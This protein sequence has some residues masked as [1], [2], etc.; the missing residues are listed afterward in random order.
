MPSNAI[1][2]SST[3]VHRSGG[4]PCGVDDMRAQ[5]GR[6]RVHPPADDVGDRACHRHAVDLRR[7][8]HRVGRDAVDEVHRAIDRVQHPGD[9]AGSGGRRIDGPADFLAENRVPGSQLRQPITQQ[10]FGLGVDDGHR[11]GRGRLRSHRGVV[12]GARVGA[13]HLARGGAGRTRPL[14]LANVSATER[15]CAGSFSGVLTG[16]SHHRSTAPRPANDREHFAADRRSAH[17]GVGDTHALAE[18]IR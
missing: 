16:P 11:V 18:E 4:V 1:D 9:R 2:N 17:Y 3:A 15:R 8:R 12:A 6:G 10:P 5:P 13:E 7:H 14:R